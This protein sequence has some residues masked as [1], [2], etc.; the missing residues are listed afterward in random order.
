MLIP[1]PP[2]KKHNLFDVVGEPAA[3]TNSLSFGY[4]PKVLAKK[5]HTLLTGH[6]TSTPSQTQKLHTRPSQ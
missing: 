5:E 1:F 4:A 3:S 2:R 6:H